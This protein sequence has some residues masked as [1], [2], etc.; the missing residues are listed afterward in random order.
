MSV[1]LGVGL[2][3][4]AGGAAGQWGPERTPV[5]IGLGVGLAGGAGGAAGQWGPERTPVSIGRLRPALDQGRRLCVLRRP[6]SLSVVSG[7]RISACLGPGSEG[8]LAFQVEH[9]KLFLFRPVR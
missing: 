8:P 3:G 7:V 1:G 9:N 4:G 2:A 6:A 5:S